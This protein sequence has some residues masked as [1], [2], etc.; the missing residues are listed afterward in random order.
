[1]MAPSVAWKV[2]ADRFRMVRLKRCLEVGV[3]K[4]VLKLVVNSLL[5]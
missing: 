1:M 2:Y 3:S 5:K 4:L